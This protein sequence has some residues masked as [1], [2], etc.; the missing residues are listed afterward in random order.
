MKICYLDDS[1]TLTREIH[2]PLSDAGHEV[3]HFSV[4]EEA[5]YAVLKND[6]DLLLVSQFE[7]QGGID[8]TGLL[9]TLRLSAEPEKRQITRVVLTGDQ[10]PENL[11]SLA[12]A[13]ANRVI[14]RRPGVNI[15]GKVFDLI[16]AVNQSQAARMN[17]GDIEKAREERIAETTQSFFNKATPATEAFAVPAD[18]STKDEG[19][20]NNI[21]EPRDDRPATTATES[22]VIKTKEPPLLSLQARIPRPLRS[23][24]INRVLYASPFVAVLTGGLIFWHFFNEHVPVEVVTVQQGTLYRSINGP[25]RVISKKEVDLTSGVTGQIYDVNVAEGDIV[26]KGKIL[27]ALD[28]REATVNIKRAEAKL[29][30]ADEE[31]A[32]A[33]RSLAQLQSEMDKQEA[34]LQMENAAKMSGDEVA[35]EKME[36]AGSP[37]DSIVVAANSFDDSP[38]TNAPSASSSSSITQ[39]KLAEKVGSAEAAV[40]E[41]K[42][43]QLLAKEDLRAARLARD[44]LNIKSPFNG[45][46]SRSFAVEG[47]WAQQSTVLFRLVDTRQPEIAIVVD[48]GDAQGVAAEQTVKMTSE[49]FTGVAWNEKILRVTANGNSG[50]AQN[51][52]AV[53]VY[54]SLGKDAPPLHYNQVVDAQIVTESRPNAI[55]LPFETVLTRNG[56]SEV[57]V[58]EKERVHYQPVETGLQALTEVEIISGLQPGQQVILPRQTLEEGQKVETTIVPEFAALE[59]EGF[60][61]RK[62]YAEVSIYSTDQLRK[63][64]ND[65]FIVDVRSQFEYDVVHIQKSMN[66]PVASKS[67]VD[68]LIDLR[69][70]D[71]TTPI[72]FY[73]N[74]HSCAK[75]YK[76]AHKAADAGFKHIYAYDSGILDWMRASRDK[77]VLLGKTPAPVVKMVSEEYFQ[78]RVVGFD[79]FKKKAKG[80]NTVVV[81]I[82][83][84][85]QRKTTMTVSSVELPLDRFIT[86]LNSD[87]FKDKQLLIFDAV[88]KQVRW[89]QYI[90][91]D[92]GYKNYFFLRHGIAGI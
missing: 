47:L 81:D 21:R 73:C 90:L 74:G 20:S 46:V 77:T 10:R 92:R 76:A 79:A 69:P 85:M 82:R 49:A 63:N 89:L 36:V 8:C 5:L 22:T 12:L 59:A 43:K 24:G 2:R 60:P 75:S 55:K 38:D 64:F 34:A 68:S 29:L 58:V 33:E 18:I 50:S 17:A 45:L 28:D 44:R 6:Y 1:F 23:K 30:V 62:D 71:G 52:N 31:L 80:K 14:L 56:R 67:F 15:V 66:I 88:G 41:A 19:T 25:G 26:K 4:P 35:F 37:D 53:T 3:D 48:G 65:I 9:R 54:A 78:S 61:L 86:E 91:E 83:D 27:A 39:A 7:P 13:G 84:E 51:N 32:F 11:K 40:I 42:A 72:V 16:E 70:K 87:R 57:A